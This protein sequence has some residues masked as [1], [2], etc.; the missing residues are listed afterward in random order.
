MPNALLAHYFNEQGLFGDI[1]FTSMKEGKP[2]EL[3]EV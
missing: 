3:F 2:E 1:D